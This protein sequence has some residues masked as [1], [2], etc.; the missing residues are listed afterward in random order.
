VSSIETVQG[1]LSGGFCGTVDQ[2][3]AVERSQHEP[4]QKFF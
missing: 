3:A 4:R 1:G 2:I